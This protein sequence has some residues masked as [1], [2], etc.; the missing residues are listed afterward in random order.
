L[1]DSEQGFGVQPTW[2][3]FLGPLTGP[4]LRPVQIPI[5]HCLHAP[6]MMTLARATGPACGS[7]HYPLLVTLQLRSQGQAPQKPWAK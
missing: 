3:V 2:R 6:E 5:D 4:L 1:V 7:D